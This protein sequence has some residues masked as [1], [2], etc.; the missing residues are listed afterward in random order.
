MKQYPTEVYESNNQ[1]YPAEG[2]QMP[3][4]RPIA[5]VFKSSG[6]KPYPAVETRPLYGTKND[7]MREETNFFNGK[8]RLKEAQV[9]DDAFLNKEKWI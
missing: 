4:I 8:P 1:M 9:N 7:L 6:G 5:T 3:Q 2:Q